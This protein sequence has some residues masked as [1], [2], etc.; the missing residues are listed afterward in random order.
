MSRPA[1]CWPNGAP[2]A[3]GIPTRTNPPSIRSCPTRKKHRL[4]R[5]GLSGG[6]FTH[7]AVDYEGIIIAQ[8]FKARGV[9][10]F[11]LRYR[12]TPLYTRN[13]AVADGQRALQYVRA[14]AAEYKISP[15][16]I[17]MI[18]F[19]AGS[20]LEAMIAFHPSPPA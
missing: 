3:T 14:H 19:S 8:W 11:V 17:G 13:D 20:E 16:R 10:A 4:R 6:A 15:D 2:G 18:G 7:R 1:C 9:A 5:G 12:I